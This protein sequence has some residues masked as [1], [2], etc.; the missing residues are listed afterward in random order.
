MT[1]QLN[2]FPS[3]LGLVQLT[4]VFQLFPFSI[5]DYLTLVL[6]LLFLSWLV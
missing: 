3:C 1:K 2:Q 4:L 6:L 5:Y